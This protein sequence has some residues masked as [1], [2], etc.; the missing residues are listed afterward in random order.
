MAGLEERERPTTLTAWLRQVAHPVVY[1][2]ARFLI[3]LGLTA[4]MVTVAGVLFAAVAG[5]LAAR[6]WF[7]WAG[8]V[9]IVGMPLDAFDGAVARLTGG[10]T[11][12]GALL[13]STLDRYGEFFVL[14]GLAYYYAVAGQPVPVVLAF[15]TLFGSVMVSYV[16]ARSE[17]L[18]IDNK[19][20]LMT[21]VERSIVTVLALLTGYVVV[22]LWLLAV[23]THF[24]VAQ[25][26]WHALRAVR[27]DDHIRDD[28]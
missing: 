10:A 20:G 8:V 18:Q 27:G 26:V 6:G 5:Y 23:L 14:A 4:N 15:V 24:T 22:G 1:G 25:R 17:G 9:L 13:D 21:R 12:S 3:R 16:R 7:F 11:R 2:V 19:V 28:H